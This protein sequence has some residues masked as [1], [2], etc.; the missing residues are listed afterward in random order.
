MALDEEEKALTAQKNAEK[1]LTEGKKRL[2]EADAEVPRA[3]KANEDAKKAV[4]KAHDNK[5]EA[6]KKADGVI[7]NLE[8]VHATKVVEQNKAST[9]QDKATEEHLKSE[10][11][12][13]NPKGFCH[14]FKDW[15]GQPTNVLEQMGATVE[16]EANSITV[17]RKEGTK[18]KGVD[19][20]CDEIP[21]AAMTLAPV[22]LFAEGPTKIRNV[23]KIGRAH[24]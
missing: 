2:E 14:A 24:V 11:Q 4:T 19:V 10:K 8:A 16:W 7:S 23:Y 13:V 15:E 17:S 21:D 1:V 9:N 12:Y 5:K 22:A 6:V 18:L 3:D 20:D